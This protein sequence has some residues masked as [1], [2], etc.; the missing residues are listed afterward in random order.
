MQQLKV[1]KW[2]KKLKPFSKC[3]TPS[4]M[5]DGNSG[6]VIPIRCMRWRC[7][8]CCVF[9]AWLLKKKIQGVMQQNAGFVGYD[10]YEKDITECV[11]M[12]TLTCPDKMY[13][14]H[15]T[16]AFH[17]FSTHLR[18]KYDFKYTWFKEYAERKSGKDKGEFVNHLHILT[19]SKVLKK[20]IDIAWKQAINDIFGEDLPFV[21][22]HVDDIPLQHAGYVS[23]YLSK[24]EF[25]EHF[26]ARERRYGSSKGFYPREVKNKNPDTSWTFFTAIQFREHFGERYADVCL[27]QGH[28]NE[29][30]DDYL[31]DIDWAAYA[32]QITKY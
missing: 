17:I 21:R 27:E 29:C 20:D 24:T 12:I 4:V 11:R 9:K 22:N 1:E 32:T 31:K 14:A 16:K 25:Q 26:E 6:K 18:K 5:V 15:I 23:K 13:N 28:T 7:P 8:S 30:S 19:F 10:K 2:K 3:P